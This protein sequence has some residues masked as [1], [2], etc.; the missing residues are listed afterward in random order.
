M[1]VNKMK[2]TMNQLTVRLA[3]NAVEFLLAGDV[4]RSNACMAALEAIR[5]GGF[6]NIKGKIEIA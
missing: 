4:K 3:R 6:E 2:L 5:E 1:E